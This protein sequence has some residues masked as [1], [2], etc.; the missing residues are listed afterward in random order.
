MTV[1]ALKREI[2]RHPDPNGSQT[3]AAWPPPP[4][5]SVGRD[6]HNPEAAAGNPPGRFPQRARPVPGSAL[7]EAEDGSGSVR[8]PLR[9]PRLPGR[10]A[11]ARGSCSKPHR[12]CLRQGSGAAA[13]VTSGMVCVCP[14][15][16]PQP[17]RRLRT[18]RF[19]ARRRQEGVSPQR[20]QVG[21]IRRLSPPPGPPRSN[22]G[23]PIRGP[24]SGGVASRL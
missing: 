10:R 6:P 21:P 19:P 18:R 15:A 16:S 14:L 4:S 1:S 5:F 17:A 12:A 22:G 9:A 24:R 11:G 20:G 8:A 7:A 2:K 23:A 3:E 13:P